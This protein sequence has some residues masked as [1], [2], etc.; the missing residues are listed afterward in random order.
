MNKLRADLPKTYHPY[1]LT[2]SP[3]DRTLQY[4]IRKIKNPQQKVYD[5]D[6]LIF[7]IIFRNMRLKNWILWP[8]LD[9]RGRLHYHGTLYMNKTILTRWYKYGKPKCEMI[10]FV[11]CRLTQGPIEWHIYCKK[12]WSFT[13]DVLE[14]DYPM[15]KINLLSKKEKLKRI[16]EEPPNTFLDYFKCDEPSRYDYVLCK[17]QCEDP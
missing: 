16:I 13:K 9:S 8:E 6:K 7:G 10:G 12:Q 5:S 2:I 15:T 1:S 4:T 11:D 14:L 3:A 17:W